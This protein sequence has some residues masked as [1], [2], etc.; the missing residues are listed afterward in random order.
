M[1]DGQ[2]APSGAG[3]QGDDPLV[4][5]HGHGS[6]TGADRRPAVGVEDDRDADRAP[7]AQPGQGLGL[8]RRQRPEDG[9]HHATQAT[10][11]QPGSRAVQR[12]RPG[13]LDG[14]EGV[15]QHA[16][17]Q[18]QPGRGQCLTALAQQGQREPRPGQ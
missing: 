14:R 1:G 11:A 15:E 13:G 8:G 4:L 2:D 16:L 7:G 6:G 12:H 17:G 18:R 3:E 9:D 5:L 10:S